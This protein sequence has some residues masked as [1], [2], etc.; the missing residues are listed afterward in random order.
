MRETDEQQPE[1]EREP[2]SAPPSEHVGLSPEEIGAEQT[3]DLPDREA[4]SMIDV[5]LA[6]PIANFAMPINE[7]LA[8][9]VNT[10]YS[11]ADATAS[12]VVIVDQSSTNTP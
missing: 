4:M 11:V 9:N 12:Q 3:T 10:N 7:A 5:G 8:S 1:R 6:F 2:E